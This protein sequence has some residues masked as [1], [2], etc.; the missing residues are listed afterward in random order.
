MEIAPE[1]LAECGLVAAGRSLAPE[2]P[3]LLDVRAIE[4]HVLVCCE[5]ED[6][7]ERPVQRQTAKSS[8][9]RRSPAVAS[10]TASVAAHQH[11]GMLAVHQGREAPPGDIAVKLDPLVSG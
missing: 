4:T 7:A 11:R 3:D 1:E 10:S 5:R 2:L 8:I 6:S 9:S